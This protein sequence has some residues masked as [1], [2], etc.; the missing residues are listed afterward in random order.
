M[1]WKGY[2]DVE[3]LG[4]VEFYPEFA[5]GTFADD[6]AWVAAAQAYGASLEAAGFVADYAIP[7]LQEFSGVYYNATSQEVAILGFSYAADES[8]DGLVIRAGGVLNAAKAGAH[9]FNVSDSSVW[10]TA[11]AY[12][13]VWDALC[14]F[15]GEEDMM[16]NGS[17]ALGYG[18]YMAQAARTQYQQTFEYY[19]FIP[20]CALSNSNNPIEEGAEHDYLYY[21]ATATEGTYVVIDFN[22]EDDTI[23]SQGQEVAVTG[24]V[25]YIST[26]TVPSGD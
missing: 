17:T 14:S 22:W 2:E 24:L 20:F 6:N 16:G 5:D 1:D 10:T 4:L 9:L 12:N 18:Y 25:V 8:I 3:G 19:G 15:F 26:Y 23:T 21:L 7:M 13:Y 11:M